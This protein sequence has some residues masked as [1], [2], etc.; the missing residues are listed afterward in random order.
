MIDYTEIRRIVEAHL[1]T[2][3]T[4]TPIW[5]ENTPGPQADE[6][7]AVQDDTI[8]VRDMGDGVLVVG[9]LIVDIYTP[10]GIGTERGREIAK[11]LAAIFGRKDIEGIHFDEPELRSSGGDPKAPHYHQYL[12][13]R[14]EVDNIGTSTC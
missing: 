1:A 14:Y 9:Q 5:Y 6:Y 10:I 3:Y 11:E 13:I 12:T 2:N 4:T 8:S 7:I